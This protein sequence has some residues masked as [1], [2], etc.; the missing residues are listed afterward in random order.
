MLN[1]KLYKLLFVIHLVAE[2][3]KLSKKPQY[4]GRFVEYGTDLDVKFSYPVT[5]CFGVKIFQKLYMSVHQKIFY[6]E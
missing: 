3:Q 1:P 4:T 2:C 6:E 5:I